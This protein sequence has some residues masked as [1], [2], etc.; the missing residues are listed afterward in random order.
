M[1]VRVRLLGGFD[2]AVAGVPVPPSAWS[3]RH[4]ASLVKLLALADNRRLHR[5]QV[6]EAL[7]PG[8]GIEASAPRFHKAA[9]FARRALGESVDGLVVRGDL[10]L[11]VPDSDVEV[12]VHE[13]LREG[14]R[15]LDDGTSEDARAALDLCPGELLP[16]DLYE[17]W[18]QGPRDAVHG[19]RVALLRQAALWEELLVQAPADEEAHL[20]LARTHSERGDRRA[21]LLQLER[22]DQAL[23]R[24]L[25]TAPSA[26]AE[27][28]R[29]QLE[30][31]RQAAP[32]R[33]A[34]QSWRL[35]GRRELGVEIR[36]RL[37]EVASGRG[38]A[39]VLVGPAGV[40][41]SA[42]LDLAQAAARRQGFRTGRGT[43]AAVEGPWPY[44]PVLEALGDLCRSHP[45][46]LDGLDD[47]YRAEIERALSGRRE[48]HWTGESGHQRLFVAAAELVRLAASDHGLLLV[49]DD[50]HEADEASLRLLH[51]LCRCATTEPV[52]VA[53][54]H[55]PLADHGRRELLDSLVARNSGRRI[56]VQ[57]LTDGAVRRLLEAEQP[58]L[59]DEQVDRI[60]QVS[61]GIPFTAIELARGQVHAGVPELLPA[62][63]EEVMA[64]FRRVAL[65]GTTFTTD[66]LLALAE[67][68]E[69]S[70]Y[71]Q[72][73]AAVSGLLVEPEEAAGHRFRHPLLREA[74]VEQLQPSARLSERRIVA[75]RLAAMGAPPS[76]V[77]HQFIAA[78]LPSR[79]VPYV[80]SAV[81]AAGALGAYRDALALVEGV[82]QHAG[83]EALPRLLARRADLLMATGDPQAAEAYA[84]A[85]PLATGT[86]QRLVRARLARAATATGDMDTAR[87]ALAGLEPEGDAADGPILVARGTIAYFSGDTETA[88]AIA[89]EARDM[90]TLVDDSWHLADLVGLQGLIAHQRGEWFERFPR[91]M[92]RTQ[93]KQRLATT[94]FDAHLC[95]AEYL[96]YGPVPYADVIAQAEDLRRKALDAGALRGVAF[97]AALV[98]EA[99]LLMGDLDAAERELAEAAELHRDI[100]APA[101][102]ALCL[103]RLAEVRLARGDRDGAQALLDR[104]LPL[105]RWSL[106]SMHLMQRL[107]GTMINCA[108]DPIA[109]R[110]VVDQAEAVIAETDSCMLCDVMFAVPAAIACADVGDLDR[111]RSYLATADASAA[112]WAGT[113]WQA[114]ALEARAH[115]ARAEGQEAEYVSLLARAGGLFERAGHARDA[116]RMVAATAGG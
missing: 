28:L 84:E 94:V 67:G 96:L 87:A 42:L 51:Y 21:A 57:P 106:V 7:W 23:R 33:T 63:P 19:V 29:R 99:R 75:E 68:D 97:A 79:A 115:L 2:V 85:L 24:E 65:L 76:R 78:G 56:E 93:G 11:L 92:R 27:K 41:K 48:L 88:W 8:L 103:Q 55:R 34:E 116:A 4:A 77:A 100:D 70:A 54:A 45:A 59:A 5:E 47:G 80:L 32:K 50:V 44:A 30:T 46:L 43:A 22:L 18:T 16:E 13:F 104:A 113:A 102:E 71:L 52:L 66:E 74:L 105:A 58:D 72:L 73:H 10:V 35:F 36:S 91:E 37:D 60:V 101:G 62:L 107:Y 31:N 26:A 82:R 64:T 111:A 17:P 9:H 95:V 81:E 6:L 90:L 89:S 3:R 109:A 15:A 40:G 69:E 20:A 1:A 53:L 61:S 25:G 108:P 39:L 114:A 83:S 38:G 110:R 14:R 98:G 12:D 49:V 112:R 86:D